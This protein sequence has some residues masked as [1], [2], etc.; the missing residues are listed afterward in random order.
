[1][2]RMNESYASHRI[3]DMVSSERPQE[4]LERH[5]VKALS[6]RELLAL[7]LR[8]GQRGVDIVTLTGHLLDRAGSLMKLMHW[9]RDDFMQ[10]HGIGAVKAAQLVTLME[11]ARRMISE[12]DGEKTKQ[13]YQKP[14]SV[15]RHFRSRMAGL[16]V[17]KFWA[18]YL[19][20]KNRLIREEEVTSG[21]ATSTLVHPREVFRGAIRCNATAVIVAHNHPSGDPTPS[22]ADI[23]VT[24][25]LKDASQAVQIDFL[26]HIVLGTKANDPN[27]IGYY[28]FNE[29]GLI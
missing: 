1:M 21:T 25:Q 9:T 7:I 12:W 16:D 19:D 6:N 10:I 23:Q 14:D 4:R 29:T 3:K 24:R 26:D 5:G 17:E 22:Q 13:S 28:S 18:L 15:A 27:K 8:S 11:L 20:R 2:N